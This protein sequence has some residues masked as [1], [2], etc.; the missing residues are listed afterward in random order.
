[1]SILFTIFAVGLHESPF[2]ELYHNYRISLWIMLTECSKTIQLEEIRK[3]VIG[4]VVDLWSIFGC[5]YTTKIADSRPHRSYTT[6]CLLMH[7]YAKHITSHQCTRKLASKVLWLVPETA[8][9]RNIFLSGEVT[10]RKELCKVSVWL[11]ADSGRIRGKSY[12]FQ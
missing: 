9:T 1:M 4:L 11:D 3:L 8:V 7:N 6:V 2:Y 12:L 5:S 10:G